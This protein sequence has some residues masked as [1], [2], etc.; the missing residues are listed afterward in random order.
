MATQV[1]NKFKYLLATK[2][3]DFSADVFRIILMKSAFVFDID[4][5]HAY[6]D[7]SAYE[8]DDGF[9]YLKFTKQLAGVTVVE[10]D[11]NDYTKVCWSSAAWTAAGGNIG[12]SCGAVIIDDT[13]TTP[14]AD[15]VIGYID[16]GG[17]QTQ[18]DGG[19]ATIANIELRI[20]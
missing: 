2:K 15:P 17:D 14:V 11:T 5:H 3:I 9:G 20:T 7:L 13:P 8:L 12:P 1:T 4:N 6:A 16:F 10:D 19:T 18:V